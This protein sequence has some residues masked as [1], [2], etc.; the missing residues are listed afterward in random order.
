MQLSSPVTGLY[1][2]EIKN[3][4]VTNAVTASSS[5]TKP[6]I[7]STVGPIYGAW[8]TSTCL[9][10]RPCNPLSA[11]GD[12][13]ANRTMR[14]CRSQMNTQREREKDNAKNP[15]KTREESWKFVDRNISSEFHGSCQFSSKLNERSHLLLCTFIFKECHVSLF[16]S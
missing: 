3:R 6:V 5:K 8:N 9:E 16:A 13:F 4:I 10:L 12:S 2:L 1:V 7:L 14:V 15:K 11:G